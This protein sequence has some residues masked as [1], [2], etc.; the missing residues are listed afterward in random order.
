MNVKRVKVPGSVPMHLARG[1]EEYRFQLDEKSKGALKESL[2][3]LKGNWSGS[4]L[5]RAALRAM[6]DRLV[7]GAGAG[8]IEKVEEEMERAR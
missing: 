7:A 8:E 1:G 3:I 5:A 6:R 4:C 2:R